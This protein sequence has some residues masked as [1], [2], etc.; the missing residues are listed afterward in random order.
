M[1]S[2]HTLVRWVHENAFASI[3]QARPCPIFGRPVHQRDSSLRLQPGTSPQTLRIP[4]RSGHPVFQSI[5]ASG[6]RFLLSVSSF[7]FRARLDSPYL[8]ISLWLASR[9][10][11]LWIQRSSLERQRDFNPHDQ[12][13]AQR[14]LQVDLTSF[15]SVILVLKLSFLISYFNFMFELQKDLPRSARLLYLHAML[16]DHGRPVLSGV[17]FALI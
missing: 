16:S 15:R 13:A 14:T 17:V 8:L 1:Q 6:S 7:R 4:L 10:S 3:V 9:Y 2:A 5:A 11:R 12:C